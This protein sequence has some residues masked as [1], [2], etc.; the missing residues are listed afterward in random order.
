MVK[1]KTCFEESDRQTFFLLPH[2][3][4][5]SLSAENNIIQIIKKIKITNEVLFHL[6]SHAIKIFSTSFGVLGLIRAQM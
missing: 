2:L 4:V 5:H 6:D 3:H 1:W